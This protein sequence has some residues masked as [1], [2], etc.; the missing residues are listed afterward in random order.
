LK[1]YPLKV[2]LITLW[3]LLPNEPSPPERLSR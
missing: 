1:I 3:S 2:L